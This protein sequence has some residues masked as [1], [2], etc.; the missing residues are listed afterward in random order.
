MICW[1]RELQLTDFR[2]T[3]LLLL[4]SMASF[5]SC[6]SKDLTQPDGNSGSSTRAPVELSPWKAAGKLAVSAEGE[7]HTA[8]FK[9]HRHD[10]NHD[11]VVLSGPFSI[12]QQVLEREGE[13]LTWRDGE[14]AR[15]LSEAWA[16]APLLRLLA[17]QNPETMAHWLLGYPEPSKNWQVE[18]LTWQAASSWML[19]EQIHIAGDGV[20]VKIFISTWEIRPL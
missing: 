20:S 14:Q 7:T 6:V 4:I 18:V 9:W 3:P 15:A 8:R 16:Q 13:S 17:M 5:L 10:L 2:L 12:N 1:L 11:T 19:P